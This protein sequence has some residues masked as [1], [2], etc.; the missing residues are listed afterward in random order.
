VILLGLIRFSGYLARGRLAARLCVL[1][2]LGALTF[3]ASACDTWVEDRIHPLNP[4]WCPDEPRDMNC[5]NPP[6][7]APPGCASS[8]ECAPLVCDVTGARTCVR[9]TA[10]EHDACTGTTPVCGANHACR[11]CSAHSECDSRVCLPNGSCAVPDQVAYVEPLAGGTD[12]GGCN[13]TLDPLFQ[14]A[15]IGDLHLRPGSPAHR[16]ADPYSVVT[17][18]AERDIDGDPRIAPATLG[19]DEPR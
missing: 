9:C 10:A 2:A 12:S 18:I 15:A 7:D 19:A 5:L 4:Q 8:S 3:G 1:C 6:P 17:G 16:A 13:S 11:G 14:D